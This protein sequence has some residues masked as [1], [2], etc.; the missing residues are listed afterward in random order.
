MA[1]AASCR[2][3]ALM[4]AAAVPR[5]SAARVPALLMRVTPAAGPR[6]SLVAAAAAAKKKGGGKAPERSPAKSSKPI[7][8][9]DDNVTLIPDGDDSGSDDGFYNEGDDDDTWFEEIGGD[10]DDDGDDA[11]LA[12]LLAGADDDDDDGALSDPSKR[13]SAEGASWGQAALEAARRVLAEEPELNGGGGGEDGEKDGDERRAAAVGDVSLFAFRVLGGGQ[14]IDVRLD[15]RRDRYGSPTM[16]QI[17]AFARAFG[18]ALELAIGTD[19]A[20]DVAVEVSSPGAE[21][22]LELPGDLRRFAALPLR[23][24][25][26][27]SEEGSKRSIKTAI[28]RIMEDGEGAIVVEGEEAAEVEARPRRGGAAAAGA[29]AE[30]E[31]AAAGTTLWRLADVKANAPTKGRGLTRKQRDQ[32]LRIPLADLVS[33]RIHVEF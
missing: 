17:E 9:D 21:R 32:R 20:A 30:E 31:A 28:L 23:V 5:L 29:A 33:V 6:R 7:E 1:A 2:A 13:V 18:N 14:R 15:S 8:E 25:Y 4:R 22:R 19:A 10:D 12:A 11:D 24:E 26:Y 3:S 27:C 16:T